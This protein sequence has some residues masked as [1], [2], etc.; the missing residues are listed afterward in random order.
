MRPI[1]QRSPIRMTS[2]TPTSHRNALHL[3]DWVQK[4]HMKT[5]SPHQRKDNQSACK[6]VQI[7]AVRLEHH[8]WGEETTRGPSVSRENIGVGEKETSEIRTDNIAN[9]QPIVDRDFLSQR[10]LTVASSRPRK[11]MEMHSFLGGPVP[12]RRVVK[13][14]RS[15]RQK[16]PSAH[17]A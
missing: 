7:S 4:K 3:I 15:H 13:V 9:R 6:C 5:S 17:E 12:E 11:R 1:L 16:R 14:V 8:E 10:P 2:T